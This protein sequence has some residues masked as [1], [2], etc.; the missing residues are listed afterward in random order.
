M[1]PALHCDGWKDGEN[2]PVAYTAP[3]AP[4]IPPPGKPQPEN[5]KPEFS[6]SNVP[7]ETQMI[8]LVVHD[9]LDGEPVDGERPGWTHYTALYLPDGSLVE[10]GESSEE[11]KGWVGPYPDDCGEYH[12]TAYFLSQPIVGKTITRAEILKQYKSLGLG[13]ANI[14]GKYTNPLGQPIS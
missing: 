1:K 14:V 11:T 8:A 12:C 4:N 5:K 3:V 13:L 10:E 6:F 2:I 9:V 7:A